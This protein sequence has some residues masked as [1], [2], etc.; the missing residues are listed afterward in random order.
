MVDNRLQEQGTQTDG[1][2]FGG[3]APP[4]EA[5]QTS[6]ESWDGTSWSTAGATLATA[7]SR[8]GAGRNTSSGT[9]I[10]G[11]I[12]PGGGGEGFN[13][14]EQYFKSVNTITAAAWSSGGALSTARQYGG[15]AG[16][17]TA[18]LYAGGE[19]G[20]GLTGQTELYN[21]STWTTAPG[22]LPSGKNYA[23]SG[24]TQTAA[25]YAG[26]SPNSS[27]SY[28]FNGSTWATSPGSLNTARF[29][30]A[31]NMGA[32]DAGVAI[33]GYGTP[34]KSTSYEQYDGSTWTASILLSFNRTT[35]VRRSWNTN[36]NV[37]SWW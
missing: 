14:T 27:A 35:A 15:S 37:Y 22:S 2:A 4:T 10:A 16:T 32:Q 5:A 19:A 6:I 21:G 20:P 36:S 3:D 29:F 17:Q 25:Y 13:A 24:G 7:R 33:S 31:V 1:L 12:G 26:G 28:N 23:T 18:A 30:A 8:A 11:G 9:W 34:S